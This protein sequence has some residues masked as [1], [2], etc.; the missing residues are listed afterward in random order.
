[1]INDIKLVGRTYDYDYADDEEKWELVVYDE[2]SEEW[3]DTG[4][5]CDNEHHAYELKELLNKEN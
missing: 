2:Q 1:M 3:N 4:I 5:Y